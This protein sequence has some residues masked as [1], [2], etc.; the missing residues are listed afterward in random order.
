M[1]WLLNSLIVAGLLVYHRRARQQ[2]TRLRAD[3]DDW[4]KLYHAARAQ[5]E[6]ARRIMHDAV[7]LTEKVTND[8]LLTMQI[9]SPNF[10][11]ARERYDA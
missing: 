6:E 5:E 2:I 3:R 1:N 11:H 7:D 8:R 9:L 10:N 4:I